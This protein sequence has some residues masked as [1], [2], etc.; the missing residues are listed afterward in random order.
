MNELKDLLRRYQPPKFAGRRDLDLSKDTLNITQTNIRYGIKSI[1]NLMILALGNTEY[2]EHNFKEDMRQLAYL[3]NDL[4]NLQ[5]F[6]Y[7]QN[8]DISYKLELMRKSK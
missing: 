2:S 8:E 3:L 5:Q 7:E 1:S 4:M 6:A